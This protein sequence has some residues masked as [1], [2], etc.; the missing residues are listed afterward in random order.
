MNLKIDYYFSSSKPKNYKRKNT[1]C[2]CLTKIINSNKCLLSDNIEVKYSIKYNDNNSIKISYNKVKKN[3]PDNWCIFDQVLELPKIFE[4]LDE[5]DYIV[6][7]SHFR[8]DK[9][10][11]P[12]I[13]YIMINNLS[14]YEMLKTK[15]DRKQK[16]T[17]IS[18]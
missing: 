17:K 1:T 9:A 13:N 6:N 5:E 4:K 11:V 14:K 18:I 10:K 2:T 7:V 12:F 15:E 3:K 8:R 16:L